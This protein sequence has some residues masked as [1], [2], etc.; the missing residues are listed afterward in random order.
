MRWTSA[1][2]RD[3]GPVSGTSSGR[4]LSP[5]SLRGDDL[6]ARPRRTGSGRSSG[7][8]V[9]R[10]LAAVSALVVLVRSPSCT[11]GTGTWS[12]PGLVAATYLG[13]HLMLRFLEHRVSPT[14]WGSHRRGHDSRRPR[15]G[16]RHLGGYLRGH[17]RGGAVGGKPVPGAHDRQVLARAVLYQVFWGRAIERHPGARPE[18]RLRP[19]PPHV[20]VG[21]GR[22]RGGVRR[23]LPAPEWCAGSTSS[24]TSTA[25][26]AGTAWGPSPR[27]CAASSVVVSTCWRARVPHSPRFPDLAARC[28]GGVVAPV[29][30]GSRLTAGSVRRV[31]W[32]GAGPRTRSPA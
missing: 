4:S 10:R 29:H 21:V 20:P 16:S 3:S 22:G 15:V 31:P 14:G 9:L 32:P 30:V 17:R 7:A 28:R 1:D 26:A 8:R 23:R 19:R 6:A 24:P 11:P 27:S 5:W 18:R 12:S 13:L 25:P 2:A